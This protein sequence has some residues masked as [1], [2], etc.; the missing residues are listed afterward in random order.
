MSST[1]E[2][3][4]FKPTVH[5]PNSKLPVLIYRTVLEPK[6]V[7]ASR[8]QEKLENN[9]WVQGGVFRT[10]TAHHFHSVTHECYAVFSGS[11]RLLLGRGPLDEPDGGIEI[12]L[13]VGDAIVLPVS[14][15]TKVMA[16]MADRCA[17]RVWHIAL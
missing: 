9:H 15:A 13:R 10:F 8:F 1:P 7:A 16:L 5:V 14:A 2:T 3:Y 6:N 11:T 12:N 17:R 4:Y